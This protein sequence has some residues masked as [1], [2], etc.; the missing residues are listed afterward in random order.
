M[1]QVNK[2]VN[3]KNMRIFLI[4]H[5]ESVANVN[6]DLYAHYQDH[7]VPLSQ[8]GYEQAQEAGRA[9]KDYL[10]KNPA[11]NGGKPR[12]WNSPFKRTRQTLDGILE[13]FGKANVD[14]IREDALLREQNYGIFGN[15]RDR[16][17]LKREFPHEYKQFQDCWEKQGSY[18]AVPPQGESVATVADRMRTFINQQV[19]LNMAAGQ[20][21]LVLVAHGVS[22]RAFEMAFMGHEPEWYHQSKLPGNCDIIKIEGDL[23]TGFTV[24]RIHE[25]KRRLDH[26]PP[27]YKTAPYGEA[28]VREVA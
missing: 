1:S 5:G 12:F 28:P 22:N 25:S 4:R 14:S 18:Y 13:T 6:G 20:E 17:V 8:F 11:K 16:E 27:D 2:R 26:L 7:N 9:L 10:A 23:E 19:M 24:E 21:D 3:A 15:I